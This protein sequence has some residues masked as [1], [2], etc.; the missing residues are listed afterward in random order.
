MLKQ[1]ILS[2]YQYGFRRK[3]STEHA[4]LELIDKISKAMDES[5][6]TMGVFIDLSKAFDTVNFEILFKK[7]QHIGIRGICLQWFK[8]Y[9]HAWTNSNCKI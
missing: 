1:K 5:K 4:N 2:K 8:D 6:Y 3:R 7:L 9:L